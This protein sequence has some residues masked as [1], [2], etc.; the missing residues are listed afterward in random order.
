MFLELYTIDL[1]YKVLEFEHL[2]TNLCRIVL[3]LC[4]WKIFFKFKRCLKNWL[5]IGYIGAVHILERLSSGYF[6]N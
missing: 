3:S 1:K 5:N 2:S 4:A 6:A